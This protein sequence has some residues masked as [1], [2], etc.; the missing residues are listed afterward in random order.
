[1]DR[2]IYSYT[3]SISGFAAMLTEE[4]KQKLSSTDGVVSIFPSRT[5]GIRRIA[6]CPGH[7]VKS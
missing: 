6:E 2:I 1:M 7:S 4:E 3:R 5:T